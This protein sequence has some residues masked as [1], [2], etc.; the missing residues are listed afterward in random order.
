[1]TL[2]AV[3]ILHIGFF[4]IQNHKMP[5]SSWLH[6]KN[7]LLTSFKLNIGHKLLRFRR[8]TLANRKIGKRPRILAT[9]NFQELFVMKFNLM[10]S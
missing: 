5:M 8:V 2:Q 10:S 4:F 9:S 7:V 1:M 3:E 6:H